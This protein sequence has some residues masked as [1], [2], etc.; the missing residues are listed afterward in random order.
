M[1][2]TP[3]LVRVSVNVNGDK[4]VDSRPCATVREAME[5]LAVKVQKLV[6]KGYPVRAL[7]MVVGRRDNETA[8]AEYGIDRVGNAEARTLAA[9]LFPD[10][11]VDVKDGGI[12]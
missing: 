1:T 7:V 5:N 2:K 6:D 9:E 8:A 3:K 12:S 10:L 11:R 4:P